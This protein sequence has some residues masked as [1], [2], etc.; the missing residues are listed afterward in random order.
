M[1]GAGARAAAAELAASCARCTAATAGVSHKLLAPGSFPA[2]TRTIG[3]LAAALT[4]SSRCF[5]IWSYCARC[6]IT[7]LK[8]TRA[9]EGMSSAEVTSLGSDLSTF[10]RGLPSAPPSSSSSSSA[11]AFFLGALLAGVFP[12]PLP[13]P[14]G[15]S[16][17]A[18]AAGP[19][20][21][22]FLVVRLRFGFEGS[23][24]GSAWGTE[25]VTA[26]AWAPLNVASGAAAAW[27]PVS[28]GSSASGRRSAAARTTSSSSCRNSRA[29]SATTRS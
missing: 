6:C 7:L 8:D 3:V 13:L 9:Q 22:S 19:S 21:A 18:S 16:A 25:A 15:L 1:V 23:E 17:E 24:A 20:P 27:D 10:L 29:A 2:M 4:S 12:L 11:V 26:A 14:L 28:I 5:R